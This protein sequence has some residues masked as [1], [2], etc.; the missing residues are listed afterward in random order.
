[1]SSPIFK[2]YPYYYAT[3]DS[4]TFAP[5]I[6]NINYWT[7]ANNVS[8]I[9][10]ESAVVSEVEYRDI[11]GGSDNALYVNFSNGGQTYSRVLV[12][13]GQYN[14]DS[15]SGKI[16]MTNSTDWETNSAIDPFI[17]SVASSLGGRIHM[18][19]TTG[20]N[21]DLQCPDSTNI[22]QMA[23]SLIAQGRDEV[24]DKI[25]NEMNCSQNDTY[26]IYVTLPQTNLYIPFQ[27][28]YDGYKSFTVW[29]SSNGYRADRYGD[30]TSNDSNNDHCPYVDTYNLG[31]NIYDGGH[32][33]TGNNGYWQ[34]FCWDST[35]TLDLRGW[36]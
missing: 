29:Y 12:P 14:I 13:G 4:K 9:I 3:D 23:S 31:S 18:S 34:A 33:T 7:A 2:I 26:N 1:M 25:T 17:S 6:Q 20:G 24:A 19:G 10:P 8:L 27:T 36:K 16:V 30:A 11:F 28:N 15:S 22:S 32:I 5:S 35:K 21:R